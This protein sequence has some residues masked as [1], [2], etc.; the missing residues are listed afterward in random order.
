MFTKLFSNRQPKDLL[1]K[2]QRLP[3]TDEVWEGSRFLAR[4]W[5][6][7][8]RKPAY[9]PYAFLLVSDRDQIMTIDLADDLPTNEQ[10]WQSLCF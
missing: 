10:I 9:R 2:V 3:Q 5:I 7:P 4:L 8:K 1:T 6:H